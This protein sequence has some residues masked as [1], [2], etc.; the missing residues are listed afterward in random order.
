MATGCA[1]V[2]TRVGAFPS[3]VE[4]GKSGVIVN[5]ADPPALAAA[6][7][8][9]INDEPARKE[10]ARSARER[11]IEHFSWDRIVDRL[12]SSESALG[13]VVE[14]HRGTLKADVLLSDRGQ[15][16]AAVIVRVLLAPDP[17]H[18]HVEKPDRTAQNPLP[19]HLV[20]LQVG[21]DAPT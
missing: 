21:S 3:L 12:R 5:R 20:A 10:M 2:L 19:A 13:G 17:E 4:D 11:A 9:L 6:I 7:E 14:H 1:V 15:S 16:D 18:A 8:R